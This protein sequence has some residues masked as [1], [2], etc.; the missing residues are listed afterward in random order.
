MAL[1]L[2]AILHADET[3]TDARFAAA[4]AARRGEPLKEVPVAPPVFNGHP[5]FARPYSLAIIHYALRVFHKDLS[6][7][8]LLICLSDPYESETRATISQKMKKSDTALTSPY[9]KNVKGE[10]VCANCGSLA[11]HHVIRDGYVK[12]WVF[13]EYCPHCGA[14]I[15]KSTGG[16]A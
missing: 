3:A 12:R 15:S 16:E 13:D 11:A 1:L 8:D 10:T 14:K 5:R 7:V 6:N 2:S 9:V 4:W